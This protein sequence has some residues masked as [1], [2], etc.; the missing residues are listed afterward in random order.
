LTVSYSSSQQYRLQGV[1]KY[2]ILGWKYGCTGK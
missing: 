1:K 2:N